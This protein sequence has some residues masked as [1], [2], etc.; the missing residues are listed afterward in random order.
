[1]QPVLISYHQFAKDE[2]PQNCAFT[3]F[4]C[5]ADK[6]PK[7]K[8][9]NVTRLC[10][11]IGEWDRPFNEWKPVGSEQIGWRKFDDL[12]LAMRFP[13]TQP[14][15]AMKVGSNESEHAVSVEYIRDE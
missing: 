7:R 3:I 12:A 10:E 14:V 5:E 1:M 6:P 15:W 9:G 8:E 4:S 11:I 13:G 2:A